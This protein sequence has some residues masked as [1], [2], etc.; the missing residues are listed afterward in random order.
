MTLTSLLLILLLAVVTLVIGAGVLALL[1]SRPTWC[2]PL[3]GAMAAM[4]L[5][6]AVTGMLVAATVN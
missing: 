3:A 2:A 1:L 6:V 5:V 4:T